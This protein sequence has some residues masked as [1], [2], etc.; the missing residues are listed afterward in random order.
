MA[1]KVVTFDRVVVPKI[2]LSRDNGGPVVAFVSYEL[3]GTNGEYAQQRSFFPTI[4]PAMAA[5]LATMYDQAEN[6]ARAREGL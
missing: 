5:Q 6:A 3:S 2:E 1:A 4:P